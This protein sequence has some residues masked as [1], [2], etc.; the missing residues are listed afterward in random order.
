MVKWLLW[1]WR[2]WLWRLLLLAITFDF[3]IERDLMRG[4]SVLRARLGLRLRLL[5][6]AKTGQPSCFFF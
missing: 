4:D 1:R 5:H 6:A 2:L 3:D